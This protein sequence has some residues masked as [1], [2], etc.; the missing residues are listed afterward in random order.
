MTV[1]EKLE[2][3]EALWNDLRRHEAQLES[4][5][6]HGDVLRERSER[7]KQGAESFLDWEEAKTLLRNRT[8]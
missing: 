8:K 3:M 5:K 2:V 6:W 1:A 4:P 7:V